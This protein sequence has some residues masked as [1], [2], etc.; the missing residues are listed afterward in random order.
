MASMPAT[1]CCPMSTPVPLDSPAVPA[2]AIIA[3]TYATAAPVQINKRRAG[4]Q[5][6]LTG[7]TSP[8][9]RTISSSVPLTIFPSERLTES[10]HRAVRR[11]LQRAHTDAARGRG[12]LEREPLNLEQPNRLSLRRRQLFNRVRQPARIVE[13]LL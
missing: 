5:I 1:T 7:F 3:S 2:T 13:T 4:D 9:R 6:R 12:L 8:D 10:H 11:H